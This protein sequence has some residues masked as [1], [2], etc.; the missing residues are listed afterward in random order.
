MKLL[1]D[2]NLSPSLVTRLTDLFPDSDHVF[3]LGLDRASESE[4]REY[5]KREAHL[6][7]TKDADFSDLCVL[8]GFPPRLFGF[9]GET[10]RQWISNDFS[11]T[12]ISKLKR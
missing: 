7:V 2:Q 5:A 6:I 1:F 3:N 11:V 4:I 10:A 12:T 8:N 9:D